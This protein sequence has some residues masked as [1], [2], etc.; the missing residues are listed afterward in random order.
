MAVMTQFVGDLL[1]VMTVFIISTIHDLTHSVNLR[2]GESRDTVDF[3]TGKKSISQNMDKQ[4][5]DTNYCILSLYTNCS[6]TIDKLT[7]PELV[8][9]SVLESLLLS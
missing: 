9:P 1:N 4:A 6:Q 7:K 2:N 5:D 8:Q 3:V